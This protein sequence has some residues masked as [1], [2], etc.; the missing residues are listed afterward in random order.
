MKTIGLAVFFAISLILA[1]LAGAASL[2]CAP[3]MPE[4]VT[5]YYF[6]GAVIDVGPDGMVLCGREDRSVLFFA[7]LAGTASPDVLVNTEGEEAQM[8]LTWPEGTVTGDQQPLV[9]HA[10]PPAGGECAKLSM[11]ATFR[12]DAVKPPRSPRALGGP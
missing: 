5:P 11:T 12:P 2:T 4:P 6:E 1:S 7:I 8:E 3:G 9:I 10:C